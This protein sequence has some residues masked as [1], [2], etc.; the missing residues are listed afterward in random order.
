MFQVKMDID[1][2][3]KRSQHP[4]ANANIFEIITFR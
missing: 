2:E 1:I 3:T 4:R